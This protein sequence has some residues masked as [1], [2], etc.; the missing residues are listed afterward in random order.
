[1]PSKVGSRGNE[2]SA[3]KLT[4]PKTTTT[5][6]DHSLQDI[7]PTADFQ[8]MRL[9]SLA[10]TPGNLL[11]L[12]RTVGNQAVS[13]LIGG[14]NGEPGEIESRTMVARYPF[15]ATIRRGP[16]KRGNE[17][18]AH[19][20][21]RSD[22]PAG[23]EHGPEEQS[24]IIEQLSQDPEGEGSA[25]EEAAPDIS[26]AEGAETGSPVEGETEAG[27]HAEAQEAESPEASEQ[28]AADGEGGVPIRVPDIEI[29]ALAELEKTDSVLGAFGYTSSIRRGGAAPTGFGVTRSF[30]SRLTGITITPLPGIFFVSATL[31]HPITY[32]VRSG[33]GPGG[34]VDIASESDPD[35]TADN[36]PTVTSDLTPNMSDLGGR[37]PRSQFWAEDLT[38]QHELVHAN[39]DQGNGPM[40]SV[41]AMMWLNGR[42]TSSEAGVRRL[43]GRI[44]AR[45]AAALL[46][47]LSTEAG[48][49]RAY[50]DGAPPYKTRADAVKAKGDRGE[51][52]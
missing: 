41:T 21:T 38:L 28:S 29:P 49:L 26:Q 2:N 47:A 48:E 11:Q 36:Y 52:S 16:P 51:Y 8:R 39:D 44:P 7:G 31:E 6:I 45:F 50:G 22:A 34:Q 19:V 30:G 3:S 15:Q 9:D 13:A 12:Q 35:I 37:P 4:K 23:E 32:Q 42:T 27:Q 1:M 18:A 24:A 10:S 40:A 33:T 46:A 25:E 20:R 5:D 14:L 17:S 43:L